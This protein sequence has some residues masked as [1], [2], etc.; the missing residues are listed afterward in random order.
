[1]RKIEVYG[2]FLSVRPYNFPHSSYQN[3][4]TQVLTKDHFFY[5][6]SQVLECSQMTHEMIMERALVNSISNLLVM[7]K[8]KR[9]SS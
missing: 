5:V 1:M 4:G 8:G 7:Y 6:F 3:M 2:L 9:L